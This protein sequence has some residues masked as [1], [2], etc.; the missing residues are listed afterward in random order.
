MKL[1]ARLG[2]TRRTTEGM[3]PGTVYTADGKTFDA[4]VAHPVSGRPF[5]PEITTVIDV[6]TRRVVGWA[7]RSPAA[8]IATCCG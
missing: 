1:K 2:F 6:A 8:A 4:S 5:R 7:A 3:E